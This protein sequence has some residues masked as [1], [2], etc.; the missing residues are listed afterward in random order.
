MSFTPPLDIGMDTHKGQV[1]TANED[2]LDCV[3]MSYGN[4]LIVADGMGGHVGGRHASSRAVEVIKRSMAKYSQAQLHPGNPQAI[5]QA[6]WEALTQA[7]AAVL[8]DAR[9]DPG[10]KGMGTTAVIGLV[11]GYNL[12]VAHVGD[13]R[14]YHIRGGLPAPVTIDHTTVQEM[15]DR[16]I[17]SMQQSK[18]HQDRHKLSRALGAEPEVEPEVRGSPIAL[19]DGD[20]VVLC[21]DGLTDVVSDDQVGGLGTSSGASSAAA[22]LVDQANKNGGPDNISVIVLQVGKPKRRS[23]V[24]RAKSVTAKKLYGVPVFAWLALGILALA[25]ALAV[26]YMMDDKETDERTNRDRT[27]K[28]S[29]E[30]DIEGPE[31]PEV[32]VEDRKAKNREKDRDRR[33]EG[34]DRKE[35]ERA[36][37]ERADRELADEREHSGR[38]EEDRGREESEGTEDEIGG[39]FYVDFGG[40]EPSGEV[41]A[42]KKPEEAKGHRKKKKIRTNRNKAK[43]QKVEH[44]T[45]KPGASSDEGDK[46]DILRLQK[47]VE[48]GTYA[49]AAKSPNATEAAESYDRAKNVLGS[50]SKKVKTACRGNVER[51]RQNIARCYLRFTKR[52]S[53]NATAA[54]TKKKRDKYCKAARGRAVDAKTYGADD[55]DMNKALGNC[56]K[57]SSK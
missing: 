34:H 53:R 22:R 54:K 30:L 14:L 19:E 3:E 43:L 1:R 49:V 10:L 46:I 47:L 44:G 21:S 7:N 32:A 28:L 25:A 56:R 18:E 35:R 4:L 9:D 37:R 26:G 20:V 24:G 57:G 40:D 8:A 45:C 31:I 27:G 36:D 39:E 5:Q 51:L 2:S 42:E 12:Y 17:I 55:R 23:I 29:V 33:H 48:K 16:N 50:A 13:S 41:A 6:L 11:I 38:P 52:A 15:V